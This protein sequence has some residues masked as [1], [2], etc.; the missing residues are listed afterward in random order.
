VLNPKQNLQS[1]YCSEANDRHEASTAELLPQHSF[2]DWTTANWPINKCAL[3]HHDSND[4]K[5][6]PY[7]LETSE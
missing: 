7:F 1:T 2:A 6:M 3:G 5:T 4:N